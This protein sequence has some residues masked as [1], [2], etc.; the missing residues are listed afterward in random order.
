MMK[1]LGVLALDGLRTRN[2]K[3]M[4]VARRSRRS[5]VPKNLRAKQS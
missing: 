3:G 2:F 4:R 1:R 5:Y